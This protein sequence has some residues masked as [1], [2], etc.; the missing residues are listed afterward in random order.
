MNVLLPMSAEDCIDPNGDY[1][2][3]TLLSTDNKPIGGVDN[4]EYAILIVTAVNNHQR[5]MEENQAMREALEQIMFVLRLWR[6]NKPKQWD[7]I[8]DAEICKAW[9]NS[10]K[11]LALAGAQ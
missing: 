10:K 6:D 7:A 9:D 1:Q 4:S 5:L 2:G 3:T 8:V 11:A